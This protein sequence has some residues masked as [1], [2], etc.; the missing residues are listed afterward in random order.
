M[1][2]RERGREI[3]RLTNVSTDRSRDR[4]RYTLLVE[5]GGLTVGASQI[6]LLKLRKLEIRRKSG[7]RVEGGRTE[8][9]VRISLPTTQITP[10]GW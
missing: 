3:N 10:A 8:P 4:D 9:Q 2:P 1:R 6:E 5:L 7:E